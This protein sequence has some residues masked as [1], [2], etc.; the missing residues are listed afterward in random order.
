MEESCSFIEVSLH[1]YFANMNKAKKPI[2]V[3]LTIFIFSLFISLI[4]GCNSNYVPPGNNVEETEC[5]NDIKGM[6]LFGFIS[7]SSINGIEY[8]KNY[9]EIYV[10]FDELIINEKETKIE[11]VYPKEFV[12]FFG[13]GNEFIDFS[14]KRISHL[15]DNY[16][17]ETKVMLT[18]YACQK[19]IVK[20]FEFEEEKT[21]KVDINIYVE[22]K[23]TLTYNNVDFIV[24]DKPKDY[25]YIG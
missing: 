7:E 20:H 4:T 16:Q 3:L 15:F 25:T 17:P 24:V 12:D 5:H 13:Y 22:E 18:S 6:R 10:S 19:S 21:F 11:I 2:I 14:D 23:I 9:L 8:E 1:I